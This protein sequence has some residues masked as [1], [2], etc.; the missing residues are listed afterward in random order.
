MLALIL[1]RY[2][3]CFYLLVSVIIVDFVWDT[4]HY[5]LNE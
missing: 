4:N 2:I 1:A 5:G 3:R